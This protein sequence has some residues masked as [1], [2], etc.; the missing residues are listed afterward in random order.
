MRGQL[1]DHYDPRRITISLSESVYILQSVAAMAFAAHEV[2]LALQDLGTA[3][4]VALVFMR[5][6]V[7]PGKALL[8][9]RKKPVKIS[10]GF[11]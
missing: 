4:A 3:P 1:T 8:L 7:P 5:L 10:I 6:P 11:A 2:G 9:T